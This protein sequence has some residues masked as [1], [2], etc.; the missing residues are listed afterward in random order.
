MKKLLFLAAI[1]L[2]TATLHAQTLRIMNTSPCTVVVTA[3]MENFGTC[4]PGPTSPYVVYVVPPSPAI[5]SYPP[6]PGGA[7]MEWRLAHVVDEGSLRCGAVPPGTCNQHVGTYPGA[8][9]SRTP[10]SCGWPQVDCVKI[11]ACNPTCPSGTSIGIGWTQW[12]GGHA[13]LEI[14]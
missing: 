14:F 9:P 3:Y 5:L 11:G 8:F 12:S 4:T 13:D 10:T 6:A 1:A 7:G 2:T